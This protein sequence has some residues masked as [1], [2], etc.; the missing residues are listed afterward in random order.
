MQRKIKTSSNW[1]NYIIKKH[2]PVIQH[3]SIGYAPARTVPTCVPHSLIL[4][5]LHWIHYCPAYPRE[6]SQTAILPSACHKNFCLIKTIIRFLQNLKV[7]LLFHPWIRCSFK[8]AT[9]A[10]VDSYWSSLLTVA[11]MVFGNF[12]ECLRAQFLTSIIYT[13]ITLFHESYSLQETYQ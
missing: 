3:L 8:I 10:K 12:S 1:H 4:C 13:L 9:P 11:A 2:F 5:S 7:V 6:K